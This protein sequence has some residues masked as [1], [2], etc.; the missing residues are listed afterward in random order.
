MAA[1]ADATNELDALKAQLADFALRHAAAEIARDPK[2]FLGSDLMKAVEASALAAV[3]AR[4]A[5]EPR[6]SA[7]AIAEEV[8]RLIRPELS[9]APTPARRARGQVVEPP[10]GLGD[11]LRRNLATVAVGLLLTAAVGGL[12]GYFLGLAVERSDA[13]ARAARAQASRLAASES[14]ADAPPPTVVELPARPASTG[15]PVG[16][17]APRK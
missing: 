7:E 11:A 17:A 10:P 4:L 15:A 5:K 3:E 16:A 12:F 14:V 6:P 8:M 13:A 9:A 2:R 1:R